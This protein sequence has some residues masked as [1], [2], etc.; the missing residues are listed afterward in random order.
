[1]Y[2]LQCHVGDSTHIVK[3]RWLSLRADVCRLPR[4][5]TIAPYYVFAYPDWVNVVALTTVG[6]VQE[7]PYVE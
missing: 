5:R 2:R 6:P 3:D 1:M 4:G 7:R